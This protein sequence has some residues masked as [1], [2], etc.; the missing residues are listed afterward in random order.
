M[1]LPLALSRLLPHALPPA[2]SNRAASASAER[3]TQRT[4][5]LKR[6]AD[7]GLSRRQAAQALGVPYS[8]VCRHIQ[9]H[10]SDVE[11]GGG[12]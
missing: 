10:M 4:A 5:G 3:S 9:Q 11:F 8:T 6:C 12:R 7:A 2:A 1:R